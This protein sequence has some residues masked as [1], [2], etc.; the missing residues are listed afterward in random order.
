MNYK[1][2]ILSLTLLTCPV[3]YAYRECAV[4]YPNATI[5]VCDSMLLNPHQR[6]LESNSD[7][8]AAV[9]GLAAIVL[10]SKY[11]NY[12]CAFKPW[13]RVERNVIKYFVNQYLLQNSVNL[14]VNLDA[15]GEVN[16]LNTDQAME[17]SWAAL[18]LI[19]A[20]APAENVLK[21]TG[22]TY[23]REQV[24]SLIGWVL[25]NSGFENLLPDSVTHSALYETTRNEVA[26]YQ[27][28]KYLDAALK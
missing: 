20:K 6:I 5:E 15:L 3:V 13:D 24:V 4:T 25:H 26:R 19:L 16:L 10:P 8:K 12:D 23:L 27:V 18:K 17:V 1:N 2:L 11:P 9:V 22:K 14:S 28:D 21:A 7:L